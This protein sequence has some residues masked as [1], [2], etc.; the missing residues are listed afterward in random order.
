MTRYIQTALMLAMILTTSAAHAEVLDKMTPVNDYFSN[1]MVT[2][3][4]ALV[5]CYIP[6]KAAMAVVILAGVYWG[7]QFFGLM[8]P[9][10]FASLRQEIEGIAYLTQ[11][12]TCMV[13]SLLALLMVCRRQL[14]PSDPRRR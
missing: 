4:A 9:E 7:F 8:D 1:M 2:L 5:A 3:L 14:P 6:F 11:F 12:M 13:I 10:I